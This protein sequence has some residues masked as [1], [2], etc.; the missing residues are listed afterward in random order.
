MQCYPKRANQGAANVREL[1]HIG[2]KKGGHGDY[3]GAAEAW[4]YRGYDR[5]E[6]R[7][8]RDGERLRSG[9]RRES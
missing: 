5:R 9:A 8:E 1:W 6:S 7:G 3:R 4:N 2:P